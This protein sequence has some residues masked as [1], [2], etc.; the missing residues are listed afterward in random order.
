MLCAGCGVFG[1]VPPEKPVSHCPPDALAQSTPDTT[2][3]TLIYRHCPRRL[4][5]HLFF[6]QVSSLEFASDGSLL[7]AWGGGRA[8]GTT[9]NKV[10]LARSFDGGATWSEPTV[11]LD[12][13]GG[14][15]ARGPLL[16]RHDGRLWITYTH[17]FGNGTGVNAKKHVGRVV[18]S[19][20]DG[21]TWTLP[22]DI[23]LPLDRP[24]LPLHK[25]VKLDDGRLAFSIYWRTFD[26]SQTHCSVVVAS[27]D[28][29]EWEVRGDVSVIG[30]RT[31]EPVLAVL[32]DGRWRMYARTN[33]GAI[34][35]T[36]SEDEGMSWSEFDSLPVPNTDTLSDIRILPD[37]RAAV[38][39]NNH[40]SRRDNLVFGVFSNPD[41]E[42]LLHMSVVDRWDE[43]AP[44]YPHL[45]I[46][47]SDA[48]VS[49]S[50]TAYTE[51]F[52]WADIAFSRE[53]IPLRRTHPNG[54]VVTKTSSFAPI[55][56]N[57]NGVDFAS[58]QVGWAVGNKGVVD[59][60]T[61]GGSKWVRQVRVVQNRMTAVAALDEQTAVAVGDDNSVV[62]RNG[63]II[64]TGDGGE[65][66]EVIEEGAIP[67]SALA[68]EGPIGVAVG[69]GTVL[70][71][72]DGG[73]TWDAPESVEETL[74]DRWLHA[75]H[76]VTPESLWAV[77]D[78][79]TVLVSND[80]GKTW[81]REEP[82]GLAGDLRG[83]HLGPDGIGIAVGQHGV[84]ATTTDAGASWSGV[85]IPIAN[86]L[87]DAVISPGGRLVAISDQGDVLEAASADA[88][89]DL[90]RSD[91]VALYYDLA[92]RQDEVWIAGWDGA[93]FPLD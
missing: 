36:D 12:P 57:I 25:P 1:E 93:V 24:S 28:L 31:L 17:Q 34:A 70:R 43:A 50:R 19:S 3:R 56:V 66:W 53:T 8:E 48:L 37:G 7:A 60:T 87:V 38:V 20:D 62:S 63:V 83:V 10:V 67:L 80:A 14:Q 86:H 33:L 85:E 16:F 68:F 91:R 61:D 11:V 44:N 41:L 2:G 52:W 21:K 55:A 78:D 30:K 79:S 69:R 4:N 54:T 5:S 35:F 18:S 59:R 65:T 15:S 6:N 32:P 64:R 39:W 92:L 26:A 9:D 42:T 88:E 58:D 72:D 47:G 81:T 49:Y 71:T 13:G 74:G 90:R 27:R 29:S 23:D 40:A 45:L 22:T 75:V 46:D 77:G 76:F 82:P 89:W 51:R 73:K 84:I